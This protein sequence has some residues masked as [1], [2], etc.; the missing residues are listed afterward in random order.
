MTGDPPTGGAAQPDDA[1]NDTPAD[2]PE[3]ALEAARE[4]ALA[5]LMTARA[6]PPPDP[7]E[8]ADQGDWRLLLVAAGF[9]LGFLAVAGRMALMAAAEPQEPRFVEIA[10]P[11]PARAEIVDR[12]GRP[13]AMNLPA[14]SAWADP[15][16]I[17]D[18]AAA[19]ARIAEVLP[20]VQ[21]DRLTDR[22]ASRRR[23][24]WIA[25]PVTPEQKQALHDLGLPGVHFSDR[26]ARIYPAGRAAAHVLGGARVADE[27]ARGALIA[28]RGGVELRHDARLSDPR[29]AEGGPLRLSL[30]LAAQLALT[31]VLRETMA[32]YDAKGV[33]GTLMDART[34]AVV[35]LA[36]LPDFDP[37]A[38]LGPDGAKDPAL[39]NLAVQETF[40]F[41]S[42]FKP[43]VAALGLE[44]RVIDM[45]TMID[46][47][48]P[49]V[50][51]GHRFRD[52]YRM[53]AEMTVSQMIAKSSN[54]ATARVAL[55]I[56][57]PALRGF[58]ADLGM[59]APTTL[60]VAEAALG[61]PRAPAPWTD[62]ST[63]TISFGYGLS[64]TQVHLAAAY[65]TLVNG[66]LRVRPTLDADAAPPGEEARVMSERASAQMRAVLRATVEEGSG[67]SAAVEGYRVGGKT[68]TANKL[69]RDGPGYDETRTLAS[70][71]AVFPV[72]EPAY[73]LVISVDEGADV[74]GRK[75]R[76]TGGALAAPAAGRVI[77]RVAP[78]LGLRPRGA[79]DAPLE[80]AAR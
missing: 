25:R 17:I 36:S 1:S 76:R 33:F 14:W 52:Y 23:F 49:L 15:A 51:F 8:G 47:R 67:R 56:G 34:G 39:V 38:P 44:R 65:A 41:G 27:G 31:T 18:P 48:G 57:T 19:A 10:A 4:A 7:G 60:E 69:N 21:V 20:A 74:T 22:L 80:F 9:A 42:V 12:V 68:G 78:I 75:P 46:A 53:P 13:L 29:A 45:D 73:V 40:E 79:E 2:T 3:D 58:L 55:E 62:L 16:Q 28:G 70:F 54:V 30:D 11:V 71:A 26:A 6:A 61:R 72:D 64:S 35:A 43:F 32:A 37:N 66:G 59:T 63:I 5:A 77:E 50:R 24:E